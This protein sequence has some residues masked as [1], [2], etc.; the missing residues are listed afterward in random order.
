LRQAHEVGAD[1]S[2]A[3][4][5]LVCRYRPLVRRYLGGALRYRPEAPDAV[6]ECEQRCWVRLVEGRFQGACPDKGRFRDYLRAVLSNLV[7]DYRRERRQALPGLDE[8]PAQEEPVG[9]DE[10]RRM[11]GLELLERAMDRL[12][13]QDEQAGQS[14][15]A[16]LLVRR[17]QPGESMDELAR[18]LSRP[19][20]ER[21]AGWVRTTLFR[22]R[23]RLGELLRQEVA[24]ELGVPT[25]EAVEEEL[26]ELGLL[27]YCQQV[28]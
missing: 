11:Y 16:A 12:R 13:R 4:D 17:D 6:D 3:R 24:G 1:R 22:A 27:V 9:A 23:Q 14:F 25:R 10:Y 18:R 26:A 28:S 20:Q 5:A 19:G 15:H 21:T 8:E 7:N 2:Q